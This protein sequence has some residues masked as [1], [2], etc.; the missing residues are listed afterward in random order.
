MVDPRDSFT[1]VFFGYP[2]LHQRL[3]NSRPGTAYLAIF[4]K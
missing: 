4:S 2:Y 1:L 3:A